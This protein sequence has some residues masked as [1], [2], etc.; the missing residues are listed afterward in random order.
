LRYE[1]GLNGEQGTEVPDTQFEICPVMALG[2]DQ[3]P[4]PVVPGQSSGRTGIRGRVGRHRRQ[5]PGRAYRLGRQQ[6]R[7]VGLLARSREALF[8]FLPRRVSISPSRRVMHRPLPCGRPYRGQGE[9]EDFS[10]TGTG[11]GGEG[12]CI[13][14]TCE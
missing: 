9:N 3:V 5:A 1:T 11:M 14:T 10:G 12:A 7:S 4:V 13:V 2:Q 6:N 8:E